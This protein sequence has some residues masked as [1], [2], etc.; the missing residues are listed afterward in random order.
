MIGNTGLGATPAYYLQ[1]G[2]GSV[3]GLTNA[4]GAETDRYRYD[5]W[6]VRTLHQG[7]TP[8]PFGYRGQWNDEATG[9]LYL[10]GFRRKEFVES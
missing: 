5:A 7:V 6:G 2:L 8:N 3:I 9:L 1:D 4:A 10:Q